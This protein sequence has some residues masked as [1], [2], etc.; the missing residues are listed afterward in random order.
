MSSPSGGRGRAPS[1]NAFWRILNLKATDEERSFCTYMYMLMHAM[2][3]L[4]LEILKHA[5]I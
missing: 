2:S 3:K 1:G 4:V 5:K